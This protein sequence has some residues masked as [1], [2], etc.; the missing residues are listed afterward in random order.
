MFPYKN[1][2]LL[3]IFLTSFFTLSNI[4][5]AIPGIP[6]AFYGTATINGQSAPDGTLIE[7]RINGVQMSNTTTIDGKYG[8]PVGSFYV[9]DSQ[10]DKTGKVIYFFADDVDMEES[11]FFSTGEVTRLDLF[12][13]EFLEIPLNKK[14]NLISI[15]LKLVDNKPETVFKDIKD[16]IASVWKYDNGKWYLWTSDEN[17]TLTEIEPG[18]GYWLL[19]KENTTLKVPINLNPIFTPPTRTLQPGWNLIGYYGINEQTETDTCGFD[20]KYGNYVY[21]AL[22]SL[23]DTQQGFPR[24]SSLYTYFNCG[25]NNA[26]W[27]GLYACV[28]K[29]WSNNKMFA[30]KG[31]WI[32]M[33]VQDT[34]APVTNCV[35]NSNLECTGVL[36]P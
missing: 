26:G 34:Y 7:A 28:G 19:A 30:G 6:H 22:N 15:P 32:E 8:Y 21:C 1:I 31:Y 23:I 12:S 10:N 35:W 11:I 25:N 20:Y 27:K 17:G 14:W 29:K 16:E 5:L 2:K 33:D 3:I 24:W 13:G 4:V 9:D 18:W 36:M